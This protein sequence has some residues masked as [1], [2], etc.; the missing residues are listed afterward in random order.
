MFSLS[1]LI[2]DGGPKKLIN[3]KYRGLSVNNLLYKLFIA[4]NVEFA[5]YLDQRLGISACKHHSTVERLCL[6][7]F[8]WLRDR[9]YS[10]LLTWPLLPRSSCD[11]LC[12]YYLCRTGRLHSSLRPLRAFVV[13]LVSS[14]S[15]WSVFPSG[16]C[17][18][19]SVGPQRLQL[20]GVVL[21]IEDRK[22][23]HQLLQIKLLIT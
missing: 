11:R 3:R 14:F 13:V 4:H 12:I 23:T 8:A 16:L 20:M 15:R 5:S 2:I 6:D 18:T 1:Q 22:P 10:D 17:S 19:L 9:S 7:V 21:T